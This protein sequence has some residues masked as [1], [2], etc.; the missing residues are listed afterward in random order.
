MANGL[1]IFVERIQGQ[2]LGSQ[3]AVVDGV[4][5]Q[6]RG[7]PDRPLERLP[8]EGLF[9]AVAQVTVAQLRAIA[10]HGAVARLERFAP[11]INATLTEFEINTPLRR[12]HFL[13]QLA[14]ESGEFNY[15][16][17]I[18][19]GAA[20][21][22]RTDLGNTQPGD[23]RRFKGRGLIQITGYFNY[24]AC[25][26]A[27]GIDLVQQPHLLSRD[28][29]ACRSA[30]WFWDWQQIN[31]AADADD[32]EWVTYVING[33]YNGFRDRVTKLAAAKAAFGLA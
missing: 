8:Y 32:V 19:S 33:G 9:P 3:D 28:D 1:K 14:H 6:L 2:T 21:E 27:L 30:G 15:V 24:R 23:G 4:I 5:R 13:A 31:R 22:G 10:P 11:H 26:D 25:G 16:E 12:A 29:L 18:A 20:Y 17:E 7:L